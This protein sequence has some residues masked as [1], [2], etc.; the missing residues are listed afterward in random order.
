MAEG[1]KRQSPGRKFGLLR[2]LQAV[3]CVADGVRERAPRNSYQIPVRLGFARL[4]VFGVLAPSNAAVA[5]G[6]RLDLALTL[7]IVHMQ[8]LGVECDALSVSCWPLCQNFC[9][10]GSRT[11]DFKAISVP[12]TAAGVSTRRQNR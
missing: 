9:T 5:Y 10:F 7:R 8:P 4:L 2:R 6:I 11:P 1:Q 12:F 3:L